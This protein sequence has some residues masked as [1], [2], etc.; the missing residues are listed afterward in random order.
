M[1]PHVGSKFVGNKSSVDRDVSSASADMVAAATACCACPS[2]QQHSAEEYEGC[3]SS[4]M[5]IIIFP[6]V[7]AITTW[8]RRGA[9]SDDHDCICTQSA[10]MKS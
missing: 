7:R 9:V 2:N 3:V 10:Y 6:A 5:H 1:L 4:H 8:Y